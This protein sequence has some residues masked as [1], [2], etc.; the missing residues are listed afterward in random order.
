[1]SEIL[2]VITPVQMRLGDTDMHG[3][4][5][6]ISYLSFLEAAHL[7]FEKKIKMIRGSIRPFVVSTT[8]NYLK[9]AGLF[10]DRIIGASPWIYPWGLADGKCSCLFVEG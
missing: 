5:N 2:E 8:I 3:H 7:E 4:V 6:N 10:D 1:M 9:P